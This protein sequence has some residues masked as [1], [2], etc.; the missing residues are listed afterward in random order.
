MFWRRERTEKGGERAGRSFSGATG[1]LK[2]PVDTRR[3]RPEI[4]PRPSSAIPDA[5]L[6]Q[7]ELSSFPRPEELA[8]L[9]CYVPAGVE[10]ESQLTFATAARIQGAVRGKITSASMVFIAAGA[11]VELEDAKLRDVVVGGVLKVKQLR[12]KRVVL[13]ATAR[14]WG[15]IICDDLIMAPGAVL[16][17]ELEVG[18]QKQI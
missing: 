16:N 7:R 6:R 13:L 4:E 9:P 12:A 3:S 14:C 10:I 17:G 2:V 15:R 5:L 18:S 8:K 1:Q 11:A